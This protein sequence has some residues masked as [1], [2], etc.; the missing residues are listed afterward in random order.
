[1]NVQVQ[2]TK[3]EFSPII[4]TITIESKEELLALYHRLNI[5]I[6]SVLQEEYSQKYNVTR[7]VFKNDYISKIWKVLYDLVYRN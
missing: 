6:D 7:D 4:V 1:M 5:K 3:K 2:E